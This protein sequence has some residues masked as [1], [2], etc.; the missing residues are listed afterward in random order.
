MI[1]TKKKK[2]TLSLYLLVK[3]HEVFK[4]VCHLRLLLKVLK[5]D[6][7]WALAWWVGD[8]LNEIHI[9]QNRVFFNKSLHF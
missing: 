8:I 6:D 2:K 1:I 5:E 9:N 4:R 7:G 3:I